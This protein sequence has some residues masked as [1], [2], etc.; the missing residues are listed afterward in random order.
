MNPYMKA[1]PLIVFSVLLNAFAQ[2]AM[3]KAVMA[4][5]MEWSLL[6]LIRL[7]LHPW[8]LTCMGCYA[9]SIVVWASAMAQVPVNFAYPFLALGFVAGAFLSKLMLGES[10]PPLRW[11]AISIIVVG[12]GL[13]TF[14]GSAT[15]AS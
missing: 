9:I 10:I 13:L 1:L 3:K 5:G 15:K 8:M 12:L 11:V 4:T 2:I 14:T 6:P 7:F